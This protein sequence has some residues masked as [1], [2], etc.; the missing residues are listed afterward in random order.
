LKE[1][2]AMGDK[3]PKNKEKRKP[4]KAEPKKAPAAPKA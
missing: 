1:A 4:K 2:I 3:S